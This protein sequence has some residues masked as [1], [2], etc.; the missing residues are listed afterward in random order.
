MRAD[1]LVLLQGSAF[2]DAD[3]PLT[4]KRLRWYDGRRPLGHGA[5]ISVQGLPAGTRTIRL[6]ATD[7]R[8]RS[9]TATQR[10]RVAAVRP[11]FLLFDAPE[12][13]RRTARSVSIRVASTV[14]ATLR[15]AG[16]RFA[17]GRT[18]RRVTVPIG[19]G[20]RALALPVRLSA[21]GPDHARHVSRT[22]AVTTGC[23]CISRMTFAL[24]WE[25]ATR[26]GLISVPDTPVGAPGAATLQLQELLHPTD[27]SRMLLAV[28]ATAITLG[29]YVVFLVAAGGLAALAIVTGAILATIVSVWL[30]LQLVRA[31]LLGASVRVSDDSIP[32]I[33]E[34]IDDVRGRLDYH[35]PVDVYITQKINPSVSLTSYFG[36]KVIVIEGSLIGDLIDGE[37]RA[38]L[39]FL[40]A[41]HFGAL[42][43]RHQR[44]SVAI[45]VL[46]G[47]KLLPYTAPF[48]LPYFRATTYSGDQIGLA[49]CGS[50]ETALTATQR[51]LVG[52][53][54]RA[55]P[56][57][58]RRRLPGGARAPPLAAAPDPDGA[59]GAAPD[60]PLRQPRAL[61][62][63]HRARRVRRLPGL[64]RRG[65]ARARGRTEAPVGLPQAGPLARTE[66]RAGR[67][68]GLRDRGVAR[69]RD[70]G[71][72]CRCASPSIPRA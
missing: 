35:R 7:A 59:P 54:G 6:V 38:Q 4:A 13:V 31:R 48:L 10:I 22:P 1:Q 14:P 40:L 58:P 67:D 24:L 17:V 51:L 25:R 50:L 18:P 29:I 42:K 72:R 3:K 57:H 30:A 47:L 43:A 56:A 45:V 39:T 16:R 53:G 5:R 61:L 28:S 60:Q 2:D 20:T 70:R 66:V 36:T 8:G 19:R 64:A 26:G 12:T 46:E 21:F 32:E 9:A 33:Q 49:C 71:W 37:T 11:Q 44:L 68:R 34:L 63:T 15:I 52:K 65:D 69:R 27:F 62:R 41:R 55:E 23:G